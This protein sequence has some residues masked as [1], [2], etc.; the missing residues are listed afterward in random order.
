MYK[1]SARKFKK[2]LTNNKLNAII[3]I[4]S[5]REVKDYEN[6]NLERWK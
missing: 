4:E 3:N 1:N 5:E 6:C 2:V